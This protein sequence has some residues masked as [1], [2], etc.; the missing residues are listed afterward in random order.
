VINLNTTGGVIKV[1][2]REFTVK[3]GNGDQKGP[4]TS[5]QKPIK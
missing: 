1:L 5:F 2:G 3:D 4:I